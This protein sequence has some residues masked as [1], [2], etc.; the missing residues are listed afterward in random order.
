M[1]EWNWLVNVGTCEIFMTTFFKHLGCK[2][3]V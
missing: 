2:K 3:V 1:Y